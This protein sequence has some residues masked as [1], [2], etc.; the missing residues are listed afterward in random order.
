MEMRICTFL[1]P[2]SHSPFL[3]LSFSTAQSLHPCAHTPLSLHSFSIHYPLCLQLELTIIN[4]F[5]LH[6][7]SIR[8]P[9]MHQK[10]INHFILNPIY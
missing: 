1:S 5:A 3:I 7:L 10:E 2:L 4:P 9:L 6:S 8:S